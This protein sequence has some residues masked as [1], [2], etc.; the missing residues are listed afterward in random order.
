MWIW[1]WYHTGEDLGKK[2]FSWLLCW[3]S[4]NRAPGKRSREVRVSDII[5]TIPPTKCRWMYKN[6]A[7]Y[8][9]VRVSDMIL[10][11][12]PT[13]CLGCI[14]MGPYAQVNVRHDNDYTT[15]Q[16]PWMYKCGAICPISTRLWVYPNVGCGTICP[17]PKA[18]ESILDLFPHSLAIELVPQ[19][20]QALTLTT[21]H[22]PTQKNPKN[23]MFSSGVVICIL[24]FV[25][26]SCFLAWWKWSFK[27]RI[28]ENVILCYSVVNGWMHSM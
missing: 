17:R 20:W 7:P 11:T 8:A 24:A 28:V 2:F 12:R 14:N 27:N 4:L 25:H 1:I 23:C 6:V 21:V 26:N 18:V 10:T 13:R 22:L 5:L 15:H 19:T 9:Q 3:P 16:V